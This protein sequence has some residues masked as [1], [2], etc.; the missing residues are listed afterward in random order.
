[1]STL[2]SPP[3]VSLVVV[4]Y[5]SVDVITDFLTSLPSGC[6]GVTNYELIIVDNASTDTTLDV[7]AELAP[8]ARVIR[9][10]GNRGYAAG[11]NAGVPICRGAAILVL[12]PDI[13]LG[14]G[15]VGRLLEEL[16]KPGLGI[17]VPK[18]VRPDGR[19]IHSLR[20]SPT[21]L[22]SFGEALLGGRVAGRV[23]ALSEVVR[24]PTA[25]EHRASYS[26]ATGAAMLIT[27]SCMEQVGA[28]DETFF[29]YSEETDF[30][31]RA[32]DRGFRLV[33]RPDATVTHVGGDAKVS[34]DLHCLQVLNRVRLF[35][36]HRGSITGACAWLLA[37]T[38]E[39]ARVLA[40]SRIHRA[41]L[42]ALVKR[43]RRPVQLQGYPLLRRADG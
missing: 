32:G 13:R 21:L 14:K 41:G 2:A 33:F 39:L 25:Y 6:E 8:E 23:P 11:I 18:L 36:K 12:N 19:L 26:W 1:M 24:D 29:L 3:R 34:P 37:L 38:G 17:A 22:R 4:T 16:D 7:V 10:E 5:N 20:R 28:W 42:L 30:A 40:G 15:S 31:L 9:L 35:A 43:S 27:S